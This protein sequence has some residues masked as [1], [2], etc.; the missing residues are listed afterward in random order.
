MSYEGSD[1]NEEVE[2]VLDD[3]E[4]DINNYYVVSN[5][6]SDDE[7]KENFF[8][9]QK[10]KVMPMT[11]LNQKLVQAMKNFQAWYDEDANKIVEQAI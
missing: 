9:W 7:A 4:N 6:N 8:G 3:N 5:S 10:I 11:T 2:T 1:E